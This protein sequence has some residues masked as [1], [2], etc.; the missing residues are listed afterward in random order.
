MSDRLVKCYGTCEKKHPKSIMKKI[1][2]K[3]Y[4]PS[5]YEEKMKEKNN[6]K[7]NRLVKCYGTCGKKYPKSIMKK[8][9]KKNYCPD[10]YEEKIKEEQDRQYLYN[11]IKETFN[12]SFPT[13]LMLGQIKEFKEKRNYTYKNIAFTIDYITR[14]KKQKMDMKYGLALVPYYYDEML[15]YYRDLQRKREQTVIQKPEIITIKIK[16]FKI[17]NEYKNKKLIDMNSLLKNN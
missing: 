10:C 2:K 4:C 3:N 8:F 12:I 14:I 9:S 16:P 17:E 1:G 7:N 6:R 15:E 13:G 5:C 11:V